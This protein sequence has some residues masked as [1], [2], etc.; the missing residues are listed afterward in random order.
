MHR[1]GC[2][3]GWGWGWLALDTG[4][5]AD[6]GGP[7]PCLEME[8]AGRK[9]VW[10]LEWRTEGESRDKEWGQDAQLGPLRKLSIRAEATGSP[11]PGAR[12]RCRTELGRRFTQARRGP[13]GDPGRYVLSRGG[14]R[15]GWRA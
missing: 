2:G 14:T 13:R 7:H 5:A 3:C 4:Q 9:G 15:E 6:P 10:W 12:R 11:R 1:R 8:K